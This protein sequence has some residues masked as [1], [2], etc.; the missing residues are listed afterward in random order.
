MDTW[1]DD[2]IT[3]CHRNNGVLINGM[4]MIKL[5]RNS[6]IVSILAPPGT[7]NN[8]TICKTIVNKDNS[9]P[10]KQFQWY[11][12]LSDVDTNGILCFVP[13][14]CDGLNAMRSKP[15]TSVMLDP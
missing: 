8:A 1:T 15:H 5:H 2:T 4:P 10:R 14:V 12:H 13:L 7:L 11:L 3:G 6:G 9:T